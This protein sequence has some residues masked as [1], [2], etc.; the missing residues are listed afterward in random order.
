M[1]IRTTNALMVS[2]AANA[3]QRHTARIGNSQEQLVTGLRVNRPSDD[4]LAARSIL[5]YR[6][7]ETQLNS[8]LQNITDAR[9][10]LDSSVSQIL[11]AKDV[12]LQAKG[13]ALESPQSFELDELATQVTHMRERL[14]QIANSQLGSQYL[15]SGNTVSTKPYAPD[16]DAYS[17]LKYVGSPNP[18]EF[19]LEQDI[20]VELYLTG[21]EI[22]HPRER[23]AT[24]Y[25]GN[26]GATAGT[27][28]DTGVGRGTLEIRHGLTTYA[29][30]SGIQAGTD[31]ATLDTI[32]GPAGT[33]TLT[34][35]D[36]S[37][38]GASGT[39]SLNGGNA[40]AFTSSDTNLQITG[41]D[42]A[43]VFVDASNITAGFN[44]TVSITSTGTLSTDGGTT[45]IAINFSSSQTVTNSLTGAITYVNSS[46]VRQTGDAHLEYTGTQDVFGV[47][48]SLED[49]LLNVRNLSA[50]ERQEA[51]SRIIGDLDRMIDHL[52][53]SAGLQSATLENLEALETRYEEVRLETRR[54]KTETESADPADVLIKLQTDQNLLQ[55][56][57]ST[58]TQLFNLNILDYL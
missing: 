41:P 56:A 28:T 48:K 6:A 20:P 52:I 26:T 54:L 1:F 37:G 44:G 27:G 10:K 47:L 43:V 38:T 15:F 19:R 31:S 5:G 17:G 58:T 49:D 7:L 23:G 13:I 12:L 21:E 25:V 29:G 36:T 39:I 3:I 32:L 11:A 33:H 42:G 55:F 40:I 30:A 4:P 18:Y 35:N 46:Q 34:I 22:F 9:A 16:S 2:R 53:N 57:Y 24:V 14:L 50:G 8:R 45:S 51:N